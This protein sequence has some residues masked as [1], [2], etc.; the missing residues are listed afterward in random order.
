MRGDEPH[1]D[2]VND[3]H[4]SLGQLLDEHLA[5]ADPRVRARIEEWARKLIDLSRRNRLLVYRATKRS[6]LVLRQH[7]PDA[8]VERLLTGKAW[9]IYTPPPVATGSQDSTTP[10]PPTLDDALLTHP[11]SPTELVTDQRDPAEIERS[12]VTIGRRAKAEFE[13]RGTHTLHAIWSLLRW[14]DPGSQEPWVAP[15]LL[16]PLELRRK[17]IRDRFE[18][19]PTDEDPTFN[20]ALRVKLEND[21]GVKL[22]EIDLE[23]MTLAEVVAAV[24]DELR[25]VPID[26][27]IEPY[28]AVGL[29]SF[30]KEPMYRD[31]VEHAELVS[32]SPAVQ[33][34]ALGAA[35]EALRP[36]LDVLVPG[37]AEL[38]DVQ[39]PEEVFS[40]LDADS[41]QRLAVEAAIRG[42]SF[43]MFGP[44]GTGKSQTISNIIAEFVARGRS[45]L[46]VSEKMAALE[47]V[48]TRL[49][50]AELGDLMLE[51]HS[52]KASRA[53]VAR[54][55]FASLNE[56]VVADDRAFGPAASTLERHRS[57]LNGYAAALHESRAPLGRSLYDVIGDVQQLE[58]VPAL[59][60]GPVDAT[61]ASPETM[62][63]ITA[64][65]ARLADVWGPVADGAAFV[66]SYAAAVSVGPVERQR[67][68]DILGEAAS[69]LDAL[70]AMETVISTDMGLP[71]PTRPEARD[72]LGQLGDLVTAPRPG[73]IQWLTT[74]DLSPHRATID[75]WSATTRDR[76]VY[77]EQLTR[78]YGDGWPGVSAE[79]AQAAVGALA[80]LDQALGRPLDQPVVTEAL[81]I[82]ADD[83]NRIVEELDRIEPVAQRLRDVLGVRAHG[84]GLIDVHTLIDVAR[85]SQD[86]YRPLGAWLGRTRLEDAEAFVEAHGPAYESERRG[87]TELTAHY[88]EAILSLS[89]DPIVDRMSRHHGRWWNL[90]RPSHRA[91][92]ATVTGLTKVGRIRVEVLQDLQAAVE[93]KAQ[94]E[95]LGAL[96]PQAT[97]HFGAYAAGLDTDIQGVRRALGAAKRLIDL[98]HD[99]TD[100]DV[101]GRR[102]T[103]ESQYDPSID[104]DADLVTTALANVEQT[105]DRLESFLAEARLVALGSASRADL[106]IALE[107]LVLHAQATSVACSTFFARR[108]ELTASVGLLRDEADA[109][110]AIDDADVHLRAT[111]QALVATFHDRWRGFDTDWTTLAD[112]LDWSLAIRRCYGGGW[113]PAP[114]AEAIINGSA[115]TL[116]WTRLRDARLAYESAAHRVASLYAASAATALTNAL[117]GDLVVGRDALT[118]R[119]DRIDQLDVWVRFQAIRA[120]LASAG[121]GAFGDA[122]IERGSLSS[123]LVHSATRAWLDAWVRSVVESDDR[124]SGFSRED[125]ERVVHA[126]R[127]ADQTLIHVARER[128]LKRY[129]V[130]KPPSVTLQ[131]GEQATVRQEA[132]KKRRLRP[133]RQLLA[134]IP[135]LL[136]RIKPCL[137]MS[138]LSVS[139]FL[140][141]TT[142][143]D[144]VIFDEASQV[145]P[146]D[147]INCI[148][149]GRQLIVAGDPK[150]LPP[151]DFFRLSATIE[152]E[153]DLDTGVDDFESVLDLASGSGFVSRPLRWHY[154][155]LDDSLIAFSNQLVYD[156][157]L[158]TFP[159]PHRDGSELGVQLVYCADGV[160][161]R[162]RTA[163]NVV[164]AKRVVEAV[165][166]ELRR[167]PT[168][169][170]GVVAFSVAQQQAIEDEWERRIRLEPDLE[171]SA[172]GD[173]LNGLFIKNLETVQ[174]DERDVI[175]FSIGYGRDEA[176]RMLMNFG[177]LN[178]QGGWRRL[179]VAVT[180]ARRR[181]IVVSSIRADDITRP[182]IGA[183]SGPPRGAELLRAYLEYAERGTLPTV[184]SHGASRGPADSEFEREVA[185]AIQ[186]LGWETVTQVGT[187]GYRI[188]IGVVS[189]ADPSRFV[190]GV[191]CDGMMY[192][193][194]KTARDRDR[195]RQSVLERLGWR[196]HRIWSQDWYGRRAAAIQRLRA[197]LEAAQTVLPPQGGA[198]S[199][200]S[201]EP[202]EPTSV[203]G[204]SIPPA[205]SILWPAPPA[206]AAAET[207]DPRAEMVD[208][209][210][211]SVR[212]RRERRETVDLHEK[213]DAARLS[214]TVPYPLAELPAYTQTWMSFHDPG[215]SWYHASMLGALVDVEG[216]VHHDYAASRLA[217]RF[218]L[219]RVGGRMADAVAAAIR[220]AS[221]SGRLVVRG[222]FLWPMPRRDLTHVRVPVPRKPDTVRTIDRIPP[223]EIDLAIL[224]LVRSA[225]TIDE[226]SLRIA[227]AR[228]LGFDR[229]AD[230]IGEHIDSR[231]NANIEAGHLVATSGGLTLSDGFRLP[232]L[233]GA[234]TR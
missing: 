16:I 192:H 63:R 118:V 97:M 32:E 78:S 213:A 87:T 37:E 104:R 25:G 189:K 102:V 121:W 193:S 17:S 5:G 167:D 11:P 15:L 43:V 156:G 56:S 67:T 40:V 166:G 126:F 81:A 44:P 160:F 181:V 66:W 217:R 72:V 182:D 140:A 57:R 4:D 88:D 187:S 231:L 53:E 208:P 50:E 18:L 133:V 7:D 106:R 227:T 33:S 212:R 233:D 71:R 112:A 228:V 59:S 20:P 70:A 209:P 42:Q 190:V 223:E 120:E 69:T 172:R 194:A 163:K 196:I 135:N 214:W 178:R 191:E 31:L 131:G 134:S 30:A 93:L 220:E 38:D 141:P 65:V 19:A 129:E 200:A 29:F 130:G 45:V 13:D 12:L 91:D 54:Q 75:A 110:I 170:L 143:F 101:L 14:T 77:L 132:A 158:I 136:P 186:G 108:R 107:D 6:T 24:R 171:A 109:R 98:P 199:S 61:T 122:A 204:R 232:P 205:A 138:P 103:F 168:N 219:K 148:Y 74:D 224:H 47:V 218:G 62:D 92:R 100:W 84:G 28:A 144:L 123:D 90:L 39:R 180:R 21:F 1:G 142:R 151:T 207:R 175:V 80:S 79:A 34:L 89:L 64:T 162:G 26:W 116:P 125:H 155:S 23:E 52:A 165:A 202:M 139:H 159:S 128:V 145:P 177:P 60:S 111:E 225:M 46:F 76:R 176:G 96:D 195:L 229:T 153:L 210:E 22:P 114:V 127:S 152:S 211:P 35:V 184:A 183:L 58:A 36:S 201:V 161:D 137:M 197:E 10:K 86:R 179:N 3:P 94:R 216:P 198:A 203:S 149:R 48:A 124:L 169:S 105:L 157:S 206:S 41:S 27:S 85:I 113:V 188:D 82:I 8:I 230:R 119:Q 146:E 147:A 49:R 51:L 73:P 2:G 222:P 226:A 154:R 174:G 95:R 150:Q 9:G 173:R 185:A 117:L 83:A 55:L 115:A 99:A 164:E 68:L 234:S 215:M 221:R